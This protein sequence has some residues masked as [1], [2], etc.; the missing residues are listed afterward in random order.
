MYSGEKCWFFFRKSVQITNLISICIV[1]ICCK[2]EKKHKH[3]YIL[4]LGNCT[5]KEL[6]I[7][8]LSLKIIL[9]LD[10][11]ETIL[12]KMTIT[13]TSNIRPWLF[14]S[15]YIFLHILSWKF[16]RIKKCFFKFSVFNCNE[17]DILTLFYNINYKLITRLQLSINIVFKVLKHICAIWWWG[18]EITINKLE[19]PM[20]AAFFL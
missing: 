1:D 10:R 13:S 14:A 6:G 17:L 7:R 2:N 15:R 19:I 11:Y 20:S 4:L 9:D 18:N 8:P 3:P 5:S 16:A 12:E